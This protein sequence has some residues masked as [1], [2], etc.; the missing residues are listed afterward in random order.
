VNGSDAVL[1][2]ISNDVLRKQSVAHLLGFDTRQFRTLAKSPEHG[3]ADG[4]NPSAQIE[5][6]LYRPHFLQRIPRRRGVI[7]PVTMPIFP[8]EDPVRPNQT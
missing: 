7:D 5:R 2:A 6:F 8:L 3:K 1:K 4:S